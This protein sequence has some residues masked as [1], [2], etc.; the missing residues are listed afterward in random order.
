MPD[1]VSTQAAESIHFTIAEWIFSNF[2]LAF[3]F[4]LDKN[5]STYT[6]ASRQQSVSLRKKIYPQLQVEQIQATTLNKLPSQIQ[7]TISID[8]HASHALIFSWD[9]MSEI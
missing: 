1:D 8:N 9:I 4:I 5:V 2:A 6:I 3:C 7:G